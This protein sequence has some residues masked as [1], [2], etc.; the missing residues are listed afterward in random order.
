MLIFVLLHRI[1]LTLAAVS[2]LCKLVSDAVF[3]EPTGVV[4]A[5]TGLG[6]ALEVKHAAVLQVQ[7]QEPKVHLSGLV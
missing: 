2:L 5:A 7:G 4:E 1:I 3:L 6:R